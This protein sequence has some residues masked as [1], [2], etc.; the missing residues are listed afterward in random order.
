[1][2]NEW[3]W[4]VRPQAESRQILH[5]LKIFIPFPNS[6][7]VN[8]NGKYHSTGYHRWVLKKIFVTHDFLELYFL[9]EAGRVGQFLTNHKRVHTIIQQYYIL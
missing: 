6:R 8:L 3:V 9:S 1:M 4:N 5:G 7:T 2:V